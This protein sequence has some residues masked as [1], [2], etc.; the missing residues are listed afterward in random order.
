MFGEDGTNISIQRHSQFKG[1]KYF[2]CYQHKWG[3][4]EVRGHERE[5]FFEVLKH[6]LIFQTT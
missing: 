4:H 6:S 5:V 2:S 3:R 1:A